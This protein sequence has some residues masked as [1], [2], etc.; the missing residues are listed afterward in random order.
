L[1]DHPHCEGIDQKGNVINLVSLVA[2]PGLVQSQ[3][4]VGA[5][6]TV[7][8]EKDTKHFVFPDLVFEEIS[9]LLVDSEHST[10]LG[11]SR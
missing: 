10:L 11:E 7:A 8:S 2:F 4:H 6:S 1:F 3:P 5:A 9:A